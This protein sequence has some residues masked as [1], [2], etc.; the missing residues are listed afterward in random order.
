[1]MASTKVIF[2]PAQ[3]DSYPKGVEFSFM[4]PILYNISLSLYKKNLSETKHNDERL[5][6]GEKESLRRPLGNE[7]E[8][9]KTFREWQLG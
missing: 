3:H 1:M 2:W 6:D 4:I 7:G 8:M 9:S 5:T